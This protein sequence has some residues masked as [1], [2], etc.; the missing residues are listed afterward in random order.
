MGFPAEPQGG[1]SVN[2]EAAG[3]LGQKLKAGYIGAMDTATF[4]LADELVAR[5]NS[6]FRGRDYDEELDRLRGSVSDL[7]EAEPVPFGAGQLA[8]GLGVGVATMGLGAG[9][10]LLGNVGRGM[11]IGAGEG[12]GYGFGSGE[13]LEDRTRQAGAGALIGGGIGIAVPGVAA[14]GRQGVSALQGAR[15]ATNLGKQVGQDAGI[16]AD[17]G[18][19]ISRLVGDGDTAS[20]RDA[21]TRAGPGAMLADASPNL[22]GALD[23]TMRNPAPGA[24]IARQRVDDRA[25]T[26]YN[27][28][29]DALS[30]NRQGPRMPPVAA[31]R[32]MGNSA[33]GQINPLYQRAYDTPIDYASDQGREIEAILQRIPGGKAQAAIAKAS[34][35][36]QYD[37]LPNAQIMAQIGDDGSVVFQEMPNVM[38]IDYI[39]RAFDEIAS[40]GKDAVTGR[41]SSV[42]AFASR[43][44]RDLRTAVKDAVPEYG[45][46][47]A[48][49]SSDIRQRGA[50]QA[51][52]ALLRPQTTVEEVAES[53]ADATPAELRS[54]RE[55]VLGQVEHIMGNVR[56]VASDQNIDA[57]QALRLYSELSSPNAQQKMQALFGDEWPAISEQVDQAGAA[58]G[59][60][61]RVAGNSATQ[62][63]QVIDALIAEEITPGAVRS[64]Q[65]IN[66]VRQAGQR[67]LGS[68]TASVGRLSDNVKAELAEYL[69]RE[70]GGQQALG[71]VV[72]A[73]ARNPVN[74]VA[75]QGLQ[76]A[77]NASGF[78]SAPYM[79]AELRSRLGL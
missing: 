54:M 1:V 58:L 22:S 44:A 10:N 59:L 20:M 4:G 67:I 66:T 17:A 28:V 47:L 70:G 78:A 42:G 39:K 34:E 13:G 21:L 46:A 52:Q 77:L 36:M 9:P 50:V 18:R 56:A 7:R 74:P 61:A 27:G 62:P 35:R 65:P 57:R 8:G 14:L 30:G 19:V 73:L 11:A 60:R 41:M 75:G 3:E 24:A 79:S 76:K 16:S 31:Q 32:A 45:E 23:A 37:G 38:Q 53:I 2:R 29:V 68:D 71:S 33:R 64:L 15:R 6:I 25:G 49:A 63:R 5:G 12:A 26:A 40:D 43:I 48:A 72:D 69:S 51:G 55:G